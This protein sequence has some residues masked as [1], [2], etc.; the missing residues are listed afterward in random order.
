MSGDKKSAC[1]RENACECVQMSKGVCV[2]SRVCAHVR[3]RQMD[4]QTDIINKS[5]QS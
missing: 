4:V 5:G 1:V 2:R 3:K